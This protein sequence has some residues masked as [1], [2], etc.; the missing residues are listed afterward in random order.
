MSIAHA[1]GDEIAMWQK[2]TERVTPEIYKQYLT[3]GNTRGFLALEKLE[4]AAEKVLREA[5]DT[6]VDGVPAVWSVYNMGFIVKTRESLFSIDLVH[7][8]DSE[9]VPMLD[10]ALITHNHADHWRQD[11]YKA[12][13]G[14]G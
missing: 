3:D 7:R 5:R 11:F 8:R 10:F 2:E 12:M 13:N 4:A 6:V 1:E 14:S 9:F